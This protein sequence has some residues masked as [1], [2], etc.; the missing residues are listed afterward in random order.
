MGKLLLSKLV[1]V[2]KAIVVCVEPIK[3]F[4]P[5]Q[6]TLP[7]TVEESKLFVVDEVIA[8]PV[9]AIE[10]VGLK[11]DDVLRPRR[12]AKLGRH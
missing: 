4:L 10:Q 2:Q 9:H 11:F 6:C 8:A 5:F 7:R 3:S 12:R 1:L